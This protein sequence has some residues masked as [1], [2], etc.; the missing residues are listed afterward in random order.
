M[1]G[2]TQLSGILSEIDQCTERFVGE[3]DH[4]KLLHGPQG[5]PLLAIFAEM[6]RKMEEAAQVP[7]PRVPSAK[8]R[9]VAESRLI[10]PGCDSEGHKPKRECRI[11]ATRG[12]CGADPE[13]SL[14][15]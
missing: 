6:K 12:T 2:P 14:S 5:E 10:S 4:L 15:L 3:L 7:H 1:S 8:R 11:N 9:R 13:L